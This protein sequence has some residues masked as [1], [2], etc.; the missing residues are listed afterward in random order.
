MVVTPKCKLL[1]IKIE[2]NLLKA[3]TQ[4]FKHNSAFQHTIFPSLDNLH[5]IGSVFTLF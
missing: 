4:A 1:I 3:D 5:F 2:W